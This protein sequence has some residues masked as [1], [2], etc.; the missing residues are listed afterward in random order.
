MNK[1]YKS[2]WN[3]V[4]RS[5]TAVS[6]AQR[7]R[8]K[9]SKTL[10]LAVFLI[11][12]ALG[13]VASAEFNSDLNGVW[14]SYW[15]F[16][17]HGH[18]IHLYDPAVSTQEQPRYVHTLV[19][20]GDNAARDY[21]DLRA[22][23]VSG[24]EF[25]LHVTDNSAQLDLDGW[26]GSLFKQS[27]LG[28]SQILVYADN[29][30]GSNT[31]SYEFHFVN[32]NNDNPELYVQSLSQD[33]D[34]KATATYL[35]GSS[36]VDKLGTTI[37][38]KPHSEET[39]IHD[40][41]R[42]EPEG[43]SDYADG[44]YVATLL[45]SISL[46]E[47][48]TLELSTSGNDE[49]WSARVEG[50]GSISYSGLDK[51]DNIL[52]IRDTHSFGNN[53]YSGATTVENL[54]LRLEKTHSLGQTTSLHALNSDIVVANGNE[55]VNGESVFEVSNLDLTSGHPF[56]VLGDASFDGASHI[57]STQE[58][59]LQVGGLL[60][61]HSDNS[62]YLS[63]SLQS[64]SAKLTNIEALGSA[65]LYIDSN[66]SSANST[67]KVEIALNGGT[68]IFNNDILKTEEALDQIHIK[69]T[70]SST[71]DANRLDLTFDPST[72]IQSDTTEIGQNT[73]LRVTG[74]SQLGSAVTLSGNSEVQNSVLQ[75]TKPNAVSGTWSIDNLTLTSKNQDDIVEVIGSQFALS[76]SDV[77]RNYS[78]WLRLSDTEFE[79]TKDTS[80][81]LGFSAGL[82]LG[83]NSMFKVTGSDTV[84]I[85]RLGWTSD[86][87]TEETG[88]ILD[89]TGFSFGQ[90]N[91]TPALSVAQLDLNGRG[92]VKLDTSSIT[93]K[94]NPEEDVNLL[95][96]DD[97]KL[98]VYQIIS[99]TTIAG[100]ASNITVDNIDATDHSKEVDLHGS[101]GSEIGTATWNY[102]ISSVLK[103]KEAGLW[104]SYNLTEIALSNSGATDKADYLT[105]NLSDPPNDDSNDSNELNELRAK[106]TGTGYV[107]VTK[108]VDTKNN[109]FR[110]TNRENDFNGTFVVDYGITMEAS[111]GSLGNEESN[112]V[113]DLQR[114]ANLTI[115]SS[116]GEESPENRTQYLS[117][118]KTTNGTH[119][120][121]THEI[122]IGVN[123]VLA[124]NLN[125]ETTWS[126]VKLD[127]AGT[128]GVV[129]G[130]LNIENASTTAGEAFSGRLY[131]VKDAILNLVDNTESYT[132]KYLSGN[133]TVGV[134]LNA[135]VGAN[136]TFTGNYFVKEGK[137]LTINQDSASQVDQSYFYLDKSATL[138]YNG[139]DDTKFGNSLTLNDDALVKFIDSEGEYIKVTDNDHILSISAVDS[140]INFDW[141]DVKDT[142]TLYS[143]YINANSQLT[144][145]FSGNQEKFS[146]DFSG[147][148]GTGE[149]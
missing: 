25:N 74:T 57:L 107:L 51:Q 127:G 19:I 15:W 97:G 12:L 84:T 29:F 86:I 96:A 66:S 125:E 50:T 73:T 88:G 133:G 9:N 148:E 47:G 119:V 58:K 59:G 63:G 44:I 130:T 109:V 17:Y 99:A 87:E 146:V 142:T 108:D 32:D 129:G 134:G 144:Y 114:G 13:G 20:G 89:L 120:D 28:H 42:D 149:L 105:L 80:T 116:S 70:N 18:E 117:G 75:I 115:L 140:T 128:L 55:V 145:E 110:I 21:T 90:D 106:L 33:G 41:D 5:W 1:V 81:H 31:D 49:V 48:K 122:S 132:F 69:V 64:G 139:V 137:T 39:G 94:Y 102:D 67:G 83:A 85:N 53:S 126:G 7:C 71:D 100:N 113:I 35:M 147:T 131:V 143:Q 76:S 14:S 37:D 62:D 6:E 104:L 16:G 30:Y 135:V 103:G 26:N 92:S 93:D 54:T 4:T 43:S 46:N 38:G 40:N 82:S 123:S 60:A 52:T 56:K 3:A 79:I 11:S 22:D 141:S 101:S 34:I 72:N 98:R 111:V 78:G 65:S 45:Q 136:V 124:L 36:A 10:K 112:A 138:I 27:T 61:I 118:L 2:I 77:L 8:G 91:S 95:E 23:V 121:D 24:Y 68:H